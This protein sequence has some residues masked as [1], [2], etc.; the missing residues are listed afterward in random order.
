MSKEFWKTKS[1]KEM[2][3]EEWES[4]CDGCGKCCLHKLEDDDTG[5]IHFTNVACKLLDP[6]TGLC[7]NYKHRKKYVPDCHQLTPKKV[8]NLQWLPSSCAYKL[9]HEGQ[10]LPKWHHLVSGSKKTVIKAG[11]SVAGKTISEEDIRCL[12]DHIVDWLS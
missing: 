5:E 3:K 4:L 9:V 11:V 1:L 2:T 10:D 12:D 8:A 7:S 6:K